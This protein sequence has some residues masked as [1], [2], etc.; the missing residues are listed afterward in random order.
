V[1]ICKEMVNVELFIPV[2][3]KA[4]KKLPP[5]FFMVFFVERLSYFSELIGRNYGELQGKAKKGESF[6]PDQKFGF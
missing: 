4:L 6:H 5:Y 1:M 3:A 2:L